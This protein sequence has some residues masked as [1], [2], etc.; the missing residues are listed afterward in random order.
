MKLSL[1]M[2]VKNEEEILS[3]TLPILAPCFDEIIAVDAES[4]DKTRDILT[5]YNAKIVIRPWNNNYS[6]ARNEVIK[7]ATGDWMMQ[8]DADEAM[9]PYS[10]NRLRARC[11]ASRKPSLVMLPRIEF[12]QD[13][14]HYDPKVYPDYQGRLFFLRMEYEYRNALHEVVYRKRETKSEWEQRRFITYNDCPIY[15]YGQCKPRGVTWL[16][17]HNYGLLQKGLPLL[18]ELPPGVVF[19]PYVGIKKFTESHPLKMVRK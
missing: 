4:T 7:Q 8:L 13:F 3:K 11:I 18:S 10:I 2:I 12:V 17:H 6:D 14:D 1:G 5:A 19:K 15:H 9:F 16:R